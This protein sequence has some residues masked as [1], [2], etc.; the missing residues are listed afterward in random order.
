M[1]TL[2]SVERGSLSSVALGDSKLMTS[3][4]E[5]EKSTH[6]KKVASRQDEKTQLGSGIAGRPEWY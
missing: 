6:F 3:I 2:Q 1:K 4:K 5:K